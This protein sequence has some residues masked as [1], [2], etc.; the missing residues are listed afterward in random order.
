MFNGYYKY[1]HAIEE[2]QWFLVVK[3]R[4]WEPG[5]LIVSARDK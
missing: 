1:M 5:V 2:G 4:E 3:L